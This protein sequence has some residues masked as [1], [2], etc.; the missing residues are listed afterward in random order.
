[1]LDTKAGEGKKDDP[2]EVAQQ[3]FDALMEGK[4][5]VVGGSIMNTIQSTAAKF[6]SEKQGAAA[7]GKQVKPNSLQ[8][9]H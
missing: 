3:G 8:K 5:H 1:M 4:D 2:A 7:Q 6:M 9:E